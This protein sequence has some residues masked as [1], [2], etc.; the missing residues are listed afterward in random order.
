MK[1][2][3]EDA[4]AGDPCWQ[5]AF[6]DLAHGLVIA[7]AKGKIVSRFTDLPLSKIRKLTRRC[8]ARIRRQAP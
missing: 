5:I 1:P 8:E 7:G 4:S 2:I 6:L 3:P